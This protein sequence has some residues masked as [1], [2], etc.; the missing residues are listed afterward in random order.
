MSNCSPPSDP[1]LCARNLCTILREKPHGPWVDGVKV[2]IQRKEVKQM[3][4]KKRRPP[5]NSQGRPSIKDGTAYYG[6]LHWPV[7]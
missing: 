2:K 4:Y 3:L 7:R 1:R 6:L 5:E